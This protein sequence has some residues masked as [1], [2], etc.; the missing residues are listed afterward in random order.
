MRCIDCAHFSFK[1]LSEKG[2]LG[3]EQ[4]KQ[5]YGLCLSE[6]GSTYNHSALYERECSFSEKADNETAENR[7]KW[8]NEAMKLS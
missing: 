5:G 3:M 2:K 6:N 8:L 1:E 7:E 4:A